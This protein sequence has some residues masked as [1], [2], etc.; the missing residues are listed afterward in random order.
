[1]QS[2]LQ[3]GNPEKAAAKV[4]KSTL[5]EKKAKM[6][7]A[8][9]AKEPSSVMDGTADLAADLPV[10]HPYRSLSIPIQSRICDTLQGRMM[11]D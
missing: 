6:P 1:M 7:W 8:Q 3:V 11:H 2:L 9:R 4:K 10:S 5:P